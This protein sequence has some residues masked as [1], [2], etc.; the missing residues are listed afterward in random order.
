[1]RWFDSPGRLSHL[2]H[3]DEIS[4]QPGTN[5]LVVVSVP[6]PDGSRGQGVSGS[7]C[8]GEQASPD[9]RKLN[10][11]PVNF[12]E[13]V[14]I[15]CSN[16]SRFQYDAYFFIREALDHTQR[17]V[18]KNKEKVRHVSGQELLNGIREYATN[19]YGPMAQTVL[20]EWGV[21]TCEDFGELVF[22][23]VEHSI[24][25]KTEKDS[26]EDFKTGYDFYDAFCKPF[27]PLQ[28]V[29]K[30]SRDKTTTLP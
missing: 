19:Q 7:E 3:I 23:M 28:K 20:E 29:R 10:M 17:I 15:I 25:A 21:K 1:L 26:R 16:D 24:L 8:E 27:L 6:L 5:S 13:A 22:I 9:A 2:D 4:I 11:Q 12:E 14:E 18:T 30:V